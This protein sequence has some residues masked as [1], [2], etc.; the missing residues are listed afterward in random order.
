MQTST[1]NPIAQVVARHRREERREILEEL[2]EDAYDDLGTIELLAGSWRR[3]IPPPSNRCRRPPSG[4][5]APR[6]WRSVLSHRQPQHHPPS[7]RLQAGPPP[8]RR[9]S[10]GV[11]EAEG[12]VSAAGPRPR[13]QGPASAC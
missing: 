4:S 12:G 10:E 8:H 1:E 3:T 13:R 5:R 2:I 11:P 9:A 7:Q 6:P